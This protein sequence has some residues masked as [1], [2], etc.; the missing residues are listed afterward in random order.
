MQVPQGIVSALA[1]MGRDRQINR[2]ADRQRLTKKKKEKKK[3]DR[4]TLT[5]TTVAVVHHE[6]GSQGSGGEVVHAA[7]PIRHIPHHDSVCLCEPG[8]YAH[9]H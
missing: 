8:W 5:E 1:Q 9:R 4:D 7:G 2:I 3:K 6:I